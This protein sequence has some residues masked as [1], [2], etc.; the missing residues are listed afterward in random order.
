MRASECLKYTGSLLYGS[1]IA[2]DRCASPAYPYKRCTLFP[3]GFTMTM[4]SQITNLTIVYSTVYSGADQR[5][6]Q[7]SASLAFVWGIPGWPVNSPHKGPVTRKM[8]P[9]H[10]VIMGW[11]FSH[12]PKESPGA[13]SN[14][15]YWIKVYDFCLI[16]HWSWILRSKSTIFQFQHWLRWWLGVDKPLSDPMIVSLLTHRCV[17][18]SQRVKVISWIWLLFH[19]MISTLVCLIPVTKNIPDL[20]LCLF[21]SSPS[22]NIRGTMGISP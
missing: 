9:F 14:A 12:Q 10:D 13:L 19:V 7:S 3:M 6:H 18:R 16:F 20:T 5:K 8:F 22:V 4:A 2:S 11:P 21:S 17:T 15:F 1:N